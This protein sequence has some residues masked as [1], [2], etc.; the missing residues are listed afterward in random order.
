MY[1]TTRRL[2]SSRIVNIEKPICAL[3]VNFVAS[4]SERYEDYGYEKVGKCGLF[5]NKDLVSG[6]IVYDYAIHC[7]TDKKK[8]SDNGV[9]FIKKYEN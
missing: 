3:C 1:K 4:K 8:C 5:G 7:R 9:H 2:V 6:K